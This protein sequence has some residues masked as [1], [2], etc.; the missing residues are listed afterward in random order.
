MSYES[1]TFYHRW[2]CDGRLLRLGTTAYED[3]TE[4]S[5]TVEGDGRRTT[6]V[7][8]NSEDFGGFAERINEAAMVAQIF[9]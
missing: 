6:F 4:Y 5:I 3:H 9:G 8:K 7:F 2:C 1:K